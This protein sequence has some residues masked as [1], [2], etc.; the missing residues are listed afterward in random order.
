MGCRVVPPI[1]NDVRSRGAPVADA[2]RQEDRMSHSLVARVCEMGLFVLLSLLSACEADR[3]LEARVGK[4]EQA[5]EAARLEAQSLHSQLK[6]IEESARA[7]VQPEVAKVLAPVNERLV[8]CLAG[9]VELAVETDSRFKELTNKGTNHAGEMV[10]AKGFVLVDSQGRVRGRMSAGK[11]GDGPPFL[12]LYGEAG[13]VK[14]GLSAQESGY[15]YLEF[16][17]GNGSSVARVGA[18]ATGSRLFLLIPGATGGFTAFANAGGQTGLRVLDERGVRAAL[19]SKESGGVTL[20][21]TH[22]QN[23]GVAATAGMS[24]FPPA[25]LLFNDKGEVVWSAAGQ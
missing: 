11:D 19:V 22:L 8:E 20:G 13:K 6:G 21:L 1:D 23:T 14:V 16:Y 25:L 24:G 4:L 9:V 15:S 7:A 5:V 2:S 12:A 10:Y 18:D 17:D 3:G